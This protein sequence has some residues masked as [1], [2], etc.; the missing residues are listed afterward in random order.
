MGIHE[1][2]G[3]SNTRW[4]FCP[5]SIAAEEGYPDIPGEAA[6]DG[7]G[8]HLLVELCLKNNVTADRYDQQIIGINHEDNP[9]GWMIH[10]DRIARATECLNYVSRRVEELSAR[11]PSCDVGVISERK[12]HAG[13]VFG[14]DDWG[15]TTD[16]TIC[17]T[18]RA[19]G[20]T[21]YIE[22]ADYKDGRGYVS[23]K[24]NSQMIGN[25][26]GCLHPYLGDP[27]AFHRGNIEGCR[28]TIIQPKTN[29][30]VRYLCSD[31][32]DDN[33][34]IDTVV[35]EARRLSI[36][37]AKTDDPNAPR[38]PGKHCQWCK[39][40]PKR[41]GNCIAQADQDLRTVETMST[42][43]TTT[44]SHGVLEHIK[45]AIADPKSLTPD[46]LSKLADAEAGVCAVFAKV[47]EEIEVRI[48]QGIAVPGY[49]M[50]PGNGSN[51][52]NAP[53][54]DIVAKLKSR[55]L[56]LSVIYPSKL[57]TPAAVMKLPDLNEAQKK[58]IKKDL[59]TYKKG[60][61]RLTK[62]AHD[63]VT[64][65]PSPGSTELMFANVPKA[66]TQP[67]PVTDDDVS[68]F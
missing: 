39:A 50:C 20:I 37:A 18:N 62:I 22:V 44:G 27:P 66:P 43:I 7:T 40:N 68:F 52:W 34:S 59:I 11:F 19:T 29:P 21:H 65:A 17:V 38:V 12:V 35:A 36:A 26:F 42:D 3:F 53:E 9:N 67:T 24:N 49:G 23:E 64:E 2:L 46:Q 1:R 28:V 47:K 4:P 10:P 57:I 51:E 5:G 55:R 54:K 8:T 33:F 61:S 14:R 56:K 32:P 13:T 31:R 15:G 45:A 63:T 60:N 48:E 30:S 58:R 6:I 16:I 41:G 25:L